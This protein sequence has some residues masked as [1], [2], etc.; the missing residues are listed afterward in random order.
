M[1]RIVAMLLIVGLFAST[2]YAAP[3]DRVGGVGVSLALPAGWHSWVPST[4]VK[5]A[6]T[7]PLTRV[8][9]VSAP[10]SF[11]A[12]GCQIG[13]YTFPATAVAIVVLEWVPVKE[14]PVPAPLPLRPTSFNSTALVLHPP[15]AVECFNGSGGSAE[16][17]EHG[18]SFDVSILAGRKASPAAVA[19]ARSVLDSLR[20][21]SR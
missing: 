5:P 16:F 20:V 1:G 13:G 15:P 18:R 17:K 6:I 12:G 3:T 7:D 11:A 21:E 4:A 2:A 10:F 19:R 9:A 8:I 14:M